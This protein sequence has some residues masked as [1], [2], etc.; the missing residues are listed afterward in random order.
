MLHAARAFKRLCSKASMVSCAVVVRLVMVLIDGFHAGTGRGVGNF[1]DNLLRQL[2]GLPNTSPKICVAVRRKQLHKIPRVP[3]LKLYVLPSLPFPAWENILIPLLCWILRPSILHSPCNSGPLVPLF[4]RRFLTLHDIIFMHGRDKVKTPTS[5]YQ[6]IGRCYLR[7]NVKI[8]C[9]RYHQ[10]FTVSD[11]SRSE[12]V[13][14]LPVDPNRVVR[15][16]EGAG[17]NFRI[18]TRPDSEKKIVLHFGSDDPR[19]N[20][21]RSVEAFMESELPKCGYKLVVMGACKR[22]QIAAP[23]D[24]QVTGVVEFRG[25]TPAGEL[26]NLLGDTLCL[27]YCSQYEGFGMPIVEFQEAGVPVITSNT[28]SCA[29]VC[30]DGGVLVDPNDTRS[31]ANALNDLHFNED[32]RL[33]LI[34]KGKINANKFSWRK[35]AE[36]LVT[37]YAEFL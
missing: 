12:I 31:I 22:A 33:D 20:T 19:K 23:I 36:E 26:G 6:R 35:C 17:T 16:Y 29:E 1:V 13:E 7:L 4:T 8:L 11:F 37:Y 24:L 18:N 32:F 25:F 5:L 3:N 27:L 30:A 2:D 21:V 10:I 14:F 28:T 9:R 34:R 15:I